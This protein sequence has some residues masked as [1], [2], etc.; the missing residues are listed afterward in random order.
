MSVDKN[1]IKEKLQKIDEFIKR[2]E[3]MDFSEDQF[4]ENVDYQDLIT[5]RLQQA[6]EISIEIATHIISSSNF[7]KPETARSSFKVLEKNKIIS[8]DLSEKLMLAASFRNI[9]VHKYEDIDF[10][11]VFRDYKEDLKSLKTFVS[12]IVK[13]LG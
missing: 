1:L 7:N 10:T 9:V 13:Y 2:I 4:L 6:V 8:K 3:A 12:E 5:F 11:Q